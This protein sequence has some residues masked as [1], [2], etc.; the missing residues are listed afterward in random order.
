MSLVRNILGLDRFRFVQ[1]MISMGR[2]GHNI[3]AGGV[4]YLDG[5]IIYIQKNL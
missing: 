5:N 4:E 2:L 3:K 1:I